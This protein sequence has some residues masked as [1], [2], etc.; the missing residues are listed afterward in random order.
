MINPPESIQKDI[1]PSDEEFDK[2]ENITPHEYDPSE[3]EVGGKKIKLPV[4]E[5]VLN[6]EANIQS[7]TI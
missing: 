7:T 4:T 2:Q 6:E 1:E 5:E 3:I